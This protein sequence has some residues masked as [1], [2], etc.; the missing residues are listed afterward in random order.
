MLNQII[1]RL[2][3]DERLSGWQVRE[4][5][6]RSTQLFLNMDREESR[7]RVDSLVYEVEILITRPAAKAEGRSKAKEKDK[8][9]DKA[10]VTGNARFNVDPAG[11]ARFKEDL[12][13]AAQAAALV[14][15]QAYAMTEVAGN[16]ARVELADP[17]IVADAE[18]QLAAAAEMLRSA[19]GRERGVRL[20]AAEFFAESM[21]T[22]YFNSQGV[23]CLSESTFFSGEFCL[24]AK[25]PKGE[26]EVFRPFKRRR[27][28]DLGLETMV[29][30]CAQQSRSGL[31]AGLPKSGNFDV[32]LSG[33]ALDHFFSWCLTQASASARYNR[34]SQAE[35]G[36]QLV[37]AAAGATPLNLSHNALIPWSVGSYK[38]DPSGTP[39]CRR[40]LI[41]NGVLKARHANARYAQYLRQAATGELGGVEVGP[42]REKEADLLKAGERPLYHLND[43]S[44]F[45]PNGVT[46][47]FSSEIRYGEEITAGGLRAVKGGSV[48]GLSKTALETARFSLETEQRERYLGPKVIRLENLSL[49][50]D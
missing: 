27:L 46:G 50:G 39:G 41:E 23:N 22:R 4:L 9:G 8:G 15:N 24:L 12:D 3:L 25:G 10:T 26:A 16:M 17:L 20:A 19:S 29:A 37:L 35:I 14:A 18:S 30:R 21:R 44:Y 43:F 45:E 31:S 42:G 5:A 48:S 33:E 32:V 1:D 6:R 38:V 11:M 34:L 13:T 7:R 36:D 40:S 49:A 47:E 28:T 2:E